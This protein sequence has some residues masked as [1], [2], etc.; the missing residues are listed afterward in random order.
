MDSHCQPLRLLNR[1]YT[2][3]SPL[4]D[5]F[6]REQV[7]S[8][9]NSNSQVNTLTILRLKSLEGQVSRI[10]LVGV[11]DRESLF[12]LTSRRFMVQDVRI[13]HKMIRPE[14]KLVQYFVQK[15]LLVT[16]RYY[17]T[18]R[19]ASSTVFDFFSNFGDVEWVGLK[20]SNGNHELSLSAT[21][22]FSIRGL[23]TDLGVQVEDI[24]V[25]IIYPEET[26]SLEYFHDDLSILQEF[27]KV[28]ENSNEPVTEI[29]NF[30]EPRQP[31]DNNESSSDGHSSIDYTDRSSFNCQDQIIQ[32]DELSQEEEDD[33]PSTL[34][35]ESPSNKWTVQKENP[36]EFF[37]ISPTEI[38]LTKH[39]LQGYTP[40]ANE[41]L[42]HGSKVIK[43]TAAEAKPTTHKNP[44]QTATRDG[45]SS[46]N[47]STMDI[48][49][50]A[51]G[52]NATNSSLNKN[53]Q[54]KSKQLTAV[55]QVEATYR[56]ISM[57]LH[58]SNKVQTQIS[59]PHI[60]SKPVCEPESSLIGLKDASA[61]NSYHCLG[62]DGS[63]LLDRIQ[64]P[65]ADFDYLNS[66]IMPEVHNKWRRFVEIKDSMRR[67]KYTEY[68]L[69]KKK[70]DQTDQS[71][72]SELGSKL[73]K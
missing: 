13:R 31:V 64:P 57:S 62:N 33:Q 66:L 71:D 37:R 67:E 69:N 5:G 16:L 25:E 4:P 20:A 42:N 54:G 48:S 72:C 55:K 68:L 56:P 19:K 45:Q 38:L 34:C 12:R 15:T 14:S 65:C 49:Q 7:L 41:Q 32:N 10:G 40:P 8:L 24:W 61:D 51:A 35:E 29:P 28:S 52:Q 18:N 43:K 9:L 60:H 6:N 11:D 53:K 27:R 3:M 47:M 44:K 23:T 2:L 73:Q 30:F 21:S 39:N 36:L 22:E 70:D 50:V 59:R 63:E 46:K 1:H 26:V 58:Q 17:S